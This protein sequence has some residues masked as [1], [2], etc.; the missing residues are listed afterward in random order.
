MTTADYLKQIDEVIEHGKYKANWQSLAHHKTPDWFTEGKFGIFI[1]F[2]IYSVPA[3]GNE[4]YSR[5]MYDPNCR[6]FEHHV[7]TYGNQKDFGYKDFISMFKAENFNAEEWVS[8][9][10]EAGAK[11]VMP[12]AEHHDGFA[13]YDTGFNRWNATA[14]GPCRDIVGE[15]KNAC[16]QKD[17]V[18]CASTHRAEH[19]FFMN[20]GRTFDSDVNDEAYADF[21][22]PAYHCAGLDSDTLHQTTAD[23]HSL[24]ASKE[25][26]EDWLVRTCELIDKYQPQ[27]LYF[28]WWIHNHSFKPYLQKLTAYYYNRAEEWGK[29]VTINYK[30][31]AFPPTVATF[32]VERGA[33]TGIS[34][35][36]WQTDTAIGK[37][38]WGYVNENYFKTSR[39]LICDLIDIVSK[40]GNLLLNVG[41]KPD[42]TITAEET[43]VL[44][45]IGA[46]LS[47]HGE[48]IYGTTFW[49]TFGEGEVN[50]EEGFF[51]DYDEKAF[52]SQDFRFTYKNGYLYAF[53]MRPDGNEVRIKTLAKKNHHDI[54]IPQ[55]TQLG[56]N[57]PVSFERTE[58]A[59]IIR[60]DTDTIT[61]LP[62]C[63]KIA[64]S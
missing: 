28:D 41:P 57:R 13:M 3:F 38:S 10:K 33:L 32:D 56:S 20:M 16:E 25:Y 23:T 47:V 15:L 24:G 34:P 55:I 58:E 61:D 49:K 39:Q 50:A 45:D 8:L 5:A 44:K 11:Y 2:G 17:I 60:P 64:I 4:W 27:V 18:F 26:L 19:Y 14:M 35:V 43:Q 46:W 31:E 62:V 12:V 21:Y 52:T 59:L 48:G 54:L 53:Q 6:E 29:E 42:G 22:G 51:K 40:N 1:H 30:H 9:F 37:C 63:F 36:P 7:H